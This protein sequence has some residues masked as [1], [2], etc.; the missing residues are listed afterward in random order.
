MIVGTAFPTIFVVTIVPTMI[1]GAK[2]SSEAV[3]TALVETA[4]TTI[5]VGTTVPTVIAGTKILWWLFQQL[6]LEQQFISI[7]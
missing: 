2:I 7:C 5:I 1:A 3:P 6:L 4:V